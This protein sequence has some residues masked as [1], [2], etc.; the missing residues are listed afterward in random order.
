M[1][2]K[3]SERYVLFMDILG[4]S[5][6][7]GISASSIDEAT[8]LIDAVEG[9]AEFKTKYAANEPDDLRTQAFSD[10]LV[11]SENASPDGLA[12]LMSAASHAAV[13][14]IA[15]G[16]FVRGGLAK[17]LLY[18][19]D[20]VV[21]GPA[22]IKAYQMEETIARYPRILVDQAVHEDCGKPD[23]KKAFSAWSVE[24]KI[25]VSDDGPPFLDVLNFIRH[26]IE[27]A[28]DKEFSDNGR[29][30]IEAALKKSIYEPRHFEKMRWLAIYWNVVASDIG[31]PLIQFPQI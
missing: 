1:E 30:A 9:I 7:V 27:L 20:Q 26:E 5:N 18:H 2:K 24:P 22:L 17:G 23:H 21:L 6:I 16:I 13:E 29:K 11:M 14:L 28:G 19:T 4:F 25:A 15:S 3:Y 12:H 31:N 10:C 8:K